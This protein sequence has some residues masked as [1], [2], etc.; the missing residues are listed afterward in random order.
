MKTRIDLIAW[1]VATFTVLLFGSVSRG[2]SPQLAPTLLGCG[3]AG[4]FWIA[5]RVVAFRLSMNRAAR[6]LSPV[7]SVAAV[8]VA[9]VAAL[10]LIVWFDIPAAR[11]VVALTLVLA[12]ISRGVYA[13]VASG[14]NNVQM[15]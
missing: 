8:L 5:L 1:I 7:L 9:A 2:L 13:E 14:E 10:L 11:G 4:F 15:A 3:I 6:W 12:S